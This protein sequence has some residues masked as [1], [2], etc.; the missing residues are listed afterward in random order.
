MTIYPAIDIFEGK[1]VRLTRGD[2]SQMTVYSKDPVTV[3]CGFREAGASFMHI[4]DLEGARSGEPACF[5]V[6][7]RIVGECGLDVEVGGGIRSA[8]VIE[9]YL[10]I[11]VKRVIL[12]TAAATEPGFTRDMAR[13]F[14]SA[15]AVGVDI[16]D[17][18]VAIKG[19]TELADYEALEFCRITAESGVGTIICTDVSKD[20]ML[21]GTNIGLYRKIRAELPMKLIAS[22]GVSTLNE[23]GTLA[24]L[25]MDGV[26]LGKA[27][28]T[29]GIDLAEA[30]KLAQTS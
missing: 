1:A 23:V 27:L 13:L 10:G 3:A 2:Y 17:G 9:K 11:G 21:G 25:G 15:I 16:K 4:V 19:W 30:I 8:E 22:G 20:G 28:Y 5:D 18:R 26:I 29:G 6:I 24:R 14:G 12:G 7:S